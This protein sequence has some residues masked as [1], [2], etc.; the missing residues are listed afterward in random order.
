MSS[1]V[2]IK[3]LS[4]F[5][6]H[7]K[8]KRPTD[9]FVKFVYNFFVP[10]ESLPPNQQLSFDRNALSFRGY[11]QTN[12]EGTPYDYDPTTGKRLVYVNGKLTQEDTLTRAVP[13]FVEVSWQLGT[14]YEHV[15]PGTFPNL[16]ELNSTGK[17]TLEE[18][19]SSVY[20]MNV[21][22]VDTTIQKRL[23][24]K[25]NVLG[26]IRPIVPLQP[27][28]GVIE[29]AQWSMLAG[30]SGNVVVVSDAVR[31]GYSSGEDGD[32]IVN[33]FDQ[34]VP[35]DTKRV[36]DLGDE[37]VPP[38]YFQAS[39]VMP[40]FQ[41]DRRVFQH[42][43]HIDPL[44]IR[45]DNRKK[46]VFSEND[47]E[48]V[49][50]LPKE[51]VRAAFVE[52]EAGAYGETIQDVLTET[53][54]LKA[55]VISKR[56]LSQ[57]IGPTGEALLT[58]KDNQI[59]VVGYIVERYR[60]G[61]VG[62]QPDKKFFVDGG[63]SKNYIDTEVTYGEIYYYSVRSVYVREALV[64][65]FTPA[66][67]AKGPELV[68]QYLASS[69]SILGRVET[70]ETQ[71]PN[72][73]DAIFFKFNYNAKR[74]LIINWQYPVGRSRDTKYFQVFRRKTIYEPFECIAELDFNNSAV[75]S[76]RRE[77]VNDDAVIKCRGPKT[78][79]EDSD[80]T[81]DSSFIYAVCSVDAHGLTSPYSYQ[82]RVTFDK[83]TNRI[84]QKSISRSGAPKQYPNFYV[85]PDEDETVSAYSLTQD[86]ISSSGKQRVKIYLDP[87]CEEFR[88]ETG[89][90]RT[91]TSVHP[92]STGG[93][94]YK[95]H[96]INLDRQKD[97]SLEIRITDL[98]ND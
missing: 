59:G 79:Y 9:L 23:Y 21:R 88:L 11:V 39:L 62:G 61:Q 34:N 6:T 16:E 18:E 14:E 77:K 68:R 42:A 8:I 28:Y 32:K 98:R 47:A 35:E 43:G 3:T 50:Q 97:D 83:S 70:K 15:S 45:T 53:P 78:F 84:E 96:F 37:V 94:V 30:F 75:K 19:I 36:N 51:P 27:G 87:V 24:R 4:R 31:A 44:G 69:P 38:A 71:P 63:L 64:E 73:P 25:A 13:R 82:T 72:E 41:Y 48:D 40:D 85:D 60:K 55:D 7:P 49:S 26:R 57:K 86:V 58:T 92:D 46:S 67:V 90:V 65:T 12:E 29:N 1:N 80:F 89:E 81:R 5:F 10:D 54:Y 20:D 52:A 95:M 66:G 93:P 33:L 2:E 91:L 76:I 74:G 17:I 22:T 56:V